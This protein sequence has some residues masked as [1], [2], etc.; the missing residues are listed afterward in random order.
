MHD[1]SQ[2]KSTTIGPAL[3]HIDDVTRRS[4]GWFRK[5][6]WSCLLFL[7]LIPTG[8]Y[9]IE[10]VWTALYFKVLFSGVSI[11]V[12]GIGNLVGWIGSFL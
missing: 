10:P 4:P 6:F 8:L 7:V 12:S 2:A 1:L 9:F 11:L 5:L 3:G